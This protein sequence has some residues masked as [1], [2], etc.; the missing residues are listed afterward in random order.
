MVGEASYR[1]V[2]VEDVRL[3]RVAEIV[4]QF[5]RHTDGRGRVEAES[6]EGIVDTDRLAP[7]HGAAPP[8][9]STSQSR[10]V[11]ADPASAVFVIHP[12]PPRQSGSP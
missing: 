11:S 8:S 3:D 4:F 7:A 9:R 2:I 1:V 12:A 5:E 6:V 10:I